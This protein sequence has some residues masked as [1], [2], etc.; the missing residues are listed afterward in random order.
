MCPLIFFKRIFLSLDCLIP[1]F[2]VIYKIEGT[3][4]IDIIAI[5]LI[6]NEVK[7]KFVKKG[8]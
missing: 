5:S 1:S 7:M 3:I 8:L 4:S 6:R 2:P